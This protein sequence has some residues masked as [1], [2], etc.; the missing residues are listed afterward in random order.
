MDKLSYRWVSA[1]K[2]QIQL[3]MEL[4][5]SCTNPSISNTKWWDVITHPCHRI[6]VVITHPCPNFGYFLLI[7]KSHS[8]ILWFYNQRNYVIRN[9][10]EIL[11]ICCKW[12]KNK[13]LGMGWGW[14]LERSGVGVGGKM[15]DFMLYNSIYCHV[16]RNFVN[17]VNLPH[18]R[19]VTNGSVCEKWNTVVICIYIPIYPSYFKFAVRN[20]I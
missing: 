19:P 12:H 15:N 18:K 1:R 17:E 8:D 7:K 14:G 20:F 5:L 3:A 16:V 10:S 11:T 2:T 13:V 6:V 4:R 9:R